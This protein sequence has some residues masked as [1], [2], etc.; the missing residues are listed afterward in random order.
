[1]NFIRK[2]WSN[3]LFGIFILLLFIP[4][5][6]KPIKV[7][8]NRLLAFSPSV[9]AESKRDVLTDYNWKLVDLEGNAVD[10]N[11][12]RGKKIV[13][14]FWATWCPPCIAEMPSMQALY[15]DY[16]DKAVFLFVTN[17]DDEKIQ[18]FLAKDMYTFPIYKEV[19]LAPELL[20]T[21]SLPTTFV[22][23]EKGEIL[24][25]KTGAANWNSEK[26]RALL[27]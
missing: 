21:N 7:F 14:N 5:T 9:T 18:K 19:S 26:V 2:H 13:L 12:Y 16:T 10:F 24:I 20:Q 4:Q 25:D 22:I 11:Q 3:I 1:M 8:V 15:D 17:D 27:D 6:G 23:N